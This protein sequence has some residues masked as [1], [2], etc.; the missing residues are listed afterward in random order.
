[1][2]KIDYVNSKVEKIKNI[3]LKSTN[4]KD[5]LTLVKNKIKELELL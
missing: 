4:N 3:L 5:T 1:M 2:K